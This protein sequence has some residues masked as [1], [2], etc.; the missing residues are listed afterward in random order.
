[1]T[2]EAMRRSIAH[3]DSDSVYG[4]L[5]QIVQLFGEET[6]IEATKQISSDIA[7]ANDRAQTLGAQLALWIDESK[8]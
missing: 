1:M 4:I 8:D 7:D 5:S 2:I 3:F 6:V